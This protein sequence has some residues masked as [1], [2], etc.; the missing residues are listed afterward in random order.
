MNEWVEIFINEKAE[1]IKRMNQGFENGYEL[2]DF[3]MTA[4]HTGAGYKYYIAYF[5]HMRKK[6]LGE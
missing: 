3:K 1:A 5:V 6:P 4:T 2:V